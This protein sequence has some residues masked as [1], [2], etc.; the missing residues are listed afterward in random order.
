MKTC[1][2]CH[3][4]HHSRA[5]YCPPCNKE[6]KAEY[7]RKN[8]EKAAEW[9]R[10]YYKVNTDTIKN[11]VKVWSEENRDK[12]D[13]KHKRWRKNNPDR[14][15]KIQQ[16]YRFS[17]RDKMADKEAR[18]RANMKVDDLTE[19]QKKQI[20]DLYWLAKDLYAVSGQVYHVD[21]ILPIAKGGKHV[22]ENLQIL[23][24][25]LNLSKGSKLDVQLFRACK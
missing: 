17:N 7:Y 14:F 24:D 8:K 23:P 6:Y 18:R 9:A 10:E 5:S 12:V 1:P 16:K 4:V 25:D 3:K 20:E 21:H 11:K 15:K 19:V 22:P 13:D 2:K